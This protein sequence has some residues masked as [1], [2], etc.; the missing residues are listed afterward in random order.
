MSL[1]DSA[2]AFRARAKALAIPDASLTL[3]N[4][5]DISSFGSYAFLVPFD[6]ASDAS[7]KTALTTVLG[8]EPSVVNL[9]KFRR[10]QFEAH[11]MILADTRL[12]VERT[13]E[14]LPR[15]LPAP[16][17][18]AR[19]EAQSR[20]L[21]GVCLTG[22][23]EPSHTLLDAIQQQAE[24]GLLSHVSLEKCTS[25]IQEMHG[26]KKD[27]MITVDLSGSFKLNTEPSAIT[28]DI[29]CEYRLRVAFFRRAVA[30]DQSNVISFS[31]HEK[32]VNTLYEHMYEMPPP[33]HFSTSR[34]QVLYADRK[35][36]TLMA[37]ET[38]NGLA[39]DGAG[40]LPADAALRLFMVDPRVTQCLAPLPGAARSS[41]PSP[42]HAEGN[43]KP[44]PAPSPKAEARR[45]KRVADRV[46]LKEAR[47]SPKGPEKG[48]GKA[49]S[50]P[51]LPAEMKG[52]WSH[53]RGQEVCRN[54]N[55]KGC[56]NA[57]P[58][59]SCSNGLHACC[60]PRCGGNHAMADCPMKTK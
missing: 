36:F 58:G 42:L 59:A 40:A 43:D 12:R 20:K 15:K 46:L 16:E 5:S 21:A 17:R 22:E 8:A 41:I 13:D 14:S 29:A 4:T 32:W 56:N 54:Y 44:Q 2:A 19:H 49:S 1:T 51:S 39:A 37:A 50:K 52:M 30:Y 7:L 38:R 28:A 31:I 33:G 55:I 25:R 27:R 57:E 11:A 53:V 35:L 3:M 47:K 9:G 34:E 18:A 45:R 60:V 26:I 48:S 23:N 10:L 24:D 6:Q